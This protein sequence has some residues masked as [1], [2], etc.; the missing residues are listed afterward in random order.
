MFEFSTPFESLGPLAGR[1]ADVSPLPLA[2]ALTFQLLKVGAMS[3]V[4]RRILQ[5][6]YPSAEIR[7]RD[8]IAPYV[9]GVGINAIIPAKA[10]LLARGALMKRRVPRSTYETLSMTVLVESLLGVVPVVCLMATALSLGVA[11]GI[12]GWTGIA[13]GAAA[14]APGEAF[15]VILTSACI[16]AFAIARTGRARARV[17]RVAVRLRQ[18]AAIFGRGRVLAQVLAAEVVVWALRLA[19]IGAFLEAF[20]LDASPHTVLLVVMVQMLSSLVPVAPNG[21]G[22]QQGLMVLALGGVASPQAILTF[23][24]GMQ[25]AI[26][27]VDVAAGAAALAVSG[28]PWRTLRDPRRTTDQ[29]A[30]APTI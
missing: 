18:G 25:A 28:T 5:A 17:R 20:G 19:C 11:P 12:G 1:L 16:V 23:A 7:V 6:A 29:I 4:W 14:R 2:L 8:T 26:A 13:P 27:V 22:A 9:A 30:L 3:Q 21:A 10:G 15:L 24:I